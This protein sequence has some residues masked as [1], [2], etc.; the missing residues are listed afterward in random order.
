MSRGLYPFQYEEESGDQLITKLAGLPPYLE[1]AQ[2]SGL[3]DSIE[4]HLQIRSSTTGWTDGQLITSIILLNIA[5]GES[6]SDIK[7]LEQDSGFTRLMRVTPL[8]RWSG[9]VEKTSPR[10]PIGQ[11]RTFPAASS[12]FRYFDSF[13]DPAQEFLRKPKKAFIPAQNDNLKAFLS[14]QRKFL[15]FVQKQHTQ[16]VATLDMDALLIPTNKKE[17]LY[18]YKGYKAYQPMN[19]WWAEQ[20]LVSH[21]EFR[22]GNVNANFDLL[23]VLREALEQL[24]VGVTKVEFR[25]DSAGYQHELLRYCEKGENARFGRIEFAVACDVSEAFREAVLEVEEKE[26]ETFIQNKDGVKIKT[27]REW[28]EV[29]FV[30]SGMGLTS[31]SPVYRFIAEREMMKDEKGKKKDEKKELPFQTMEIG[32][33]KYK[34]FG[35]VTNKKQKKESDDDEKKWDGNDVLNW[36]NERCGKDEESHSVLKSD[37]AG[38]KLPSGKFGVNAAW[39]W[40]TVLSLNLNN[41]F[42]R[43]VLGESWLGK[44]M[45]AL[46]FEFIN[47]AARV[48]ERSRQILAKI[49][50]KHPNVGLLLESRQIILELC[51]GP[52]G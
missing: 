31:K 12:L 4:R 7:I 18:C 35:R 9:D 19:I 33:Q 50:R 17:A 30:P 23:R 52:S 41:A 38:G 25:S 16:S 20:Q 44:R 37:L 42:K 1:F 21:T 2:V 14:I 40:I 6:I 34:L 46:R 47:I 3:L 29:C 51:H 27:N 28:A 22:D 11:K 39:W 32:G 10:W 26:W 24:P 13:H 8:F 15:Q 48:F 5:G 43:L 36:L 49:E 45:K